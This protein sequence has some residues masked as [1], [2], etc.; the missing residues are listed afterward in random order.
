MANSAQ[1]F[2]DFVTIVGFVFVTWCKI[3]QGGEQRKTGKVI[4][5]IWSFAIVAAMAN[6]LA[7]V[8]YLLTA[9]A[10]K[11]GDDKR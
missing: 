11:D 8:F 2:V 7:T 4:N 5:V 10:E 9:K 3:S 1:L 6:T